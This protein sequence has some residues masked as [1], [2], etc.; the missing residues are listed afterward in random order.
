MVLTSISIFIIYDK[1]YTNTYTFMSIGDGLSLGLNP[2]GIKSYNYNDYV[3]EYLKDRNKEVDY[4]NYSE[5]DISIKELTNEIIYMNNNNLKQYLRK[6]N[7]II[8]SIGEHEIATNKTT[9]SIKEDLERLIKELKRYNN[10]ICLLGRYYFNNKLINKINEINKIYKDIAKDNN[11]SYINI[12]PI[13]LYLTNNTN[14]Y[15]SIKGYEN[16]SY[17]IIKA[18]NLDKN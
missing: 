15:P 1:T 8:L 17:S 11:I 13:S 2:N 10:N 9:L 6:S 16:I 14:Y 4:F 7:L 18:M 3:K 12:E 5:K